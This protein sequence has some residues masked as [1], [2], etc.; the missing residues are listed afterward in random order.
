MLINGFYPQPL[1]FQDIW[2]NIPQVACCSIS[3]SCQKILFGEVC[4]RLTTWLLLFVCFLVNSD[5]SLECDTARF[6]DA[7]GLTV[8]SKVFCKACSF[9]SL[10]LSTFSF[11]IG[12]LAGWLF[13]GWLFSLSPLNDYI[14]MHSNTSNAAAS[15]FTY[16]KEKVVT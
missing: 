2:P 5:K 16:Q 1:Q 8:F 12:G 7:V 11:T 6:S 13:T 3:A 4:V 14:Y 15:F 9:L 10:L